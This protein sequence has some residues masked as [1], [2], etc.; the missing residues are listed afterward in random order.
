[1]TNVTYEQVLTIL[2]GWVGTTADKYEKWQET[3]DSLL[4]PPPPPPST[5]AQLAQYIAD[6]YS[7][8]PIPTE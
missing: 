7:G 5:D 2:R 1:M 3:F 8:P 4:P 6:N